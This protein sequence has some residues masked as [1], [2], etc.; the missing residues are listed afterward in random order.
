[1]AEG[2]RWV[3]CRVGCRRGVWRTGGQVLVWLLLL[4][5]VDVACRLVRSGRHVLDPQLRWWEALVGG[6]EEWRCC[7]KC[8]G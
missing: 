4:F 1:M 5:G 3:I 8:A 7:S 2:G 6:D